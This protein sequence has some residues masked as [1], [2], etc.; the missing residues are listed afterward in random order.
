MKKLKTESN[1]KLNSDIA[2]E[3]LS[4]FIM[5]TSIVL[6]TNGLLLDLQ[7]KNLKEKKIKNY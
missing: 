7:Q 1:N 4:I 6:W 2:I 3:F 5:K